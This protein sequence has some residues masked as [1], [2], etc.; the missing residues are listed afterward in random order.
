MGKRYDYEVGHTL[1]GLPSEDVV[2]DRLSSYV[3]LNHASPF[4]VI[5]PY[6]IGAY[7]FL[8]RLKPNEMQHKLIKY[9]VIK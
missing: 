3:L 7:T 4:F 1:K 6:D 5:G 9:F 8:T 2:S